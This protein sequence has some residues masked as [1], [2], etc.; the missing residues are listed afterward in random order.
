MPHVKVSTSGRS[1]TRQRRRGADCVP[2]NDS[3]IADRQTHSAGH[4]SGDRD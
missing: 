3:R 2:E 4:P 1:S